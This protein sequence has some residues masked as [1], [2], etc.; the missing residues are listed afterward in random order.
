MIEDF[1]LHKIFTYIQRNKAAKIDDLINTVGP[2]ALLVTT[3]EGF[4]PLQMAALT[5]AKNE[6]NDA[7]KKVFAIIA[8]AHIRHGIINFDVTDP[9]LP[10]GVSYLSCAI[11]SENEEV[12]RIFLDIALSHGL[13]A[14]LFK[15]LFRSAL[16]RDQKIIK[17][18]FEASIFKVCAE[19]E[20][21]SFQENIAHP[22]HGLVY[23]IAYQAG[24]TDWNLAEDLLSRNRKK[25][26]AAL[27][28]ILHAFSETEW[29]KGNFFSLLC[30]NPCLMVE[31]VD[32]YGPSLV[33][34]INDGL[35]FDCH[36]NYRNFVMIAAAQRGDIAEIKELLQQG[37]LLC[38]PMDT[39]EY[40]DNS[41]N[42][43]EFTEFRGAPIVYAI[44]AGNEDAALF[45][46]DCGASH[47]YLVEFNH[48]SYYQRPI[49]QLAI[50]HGLANLVTRLIENYDYQLDDLLRVP[51]DSSEL[52]YFFNLTKVLPLI[53]GQ[54]ARARFKSLTIRLVMSLQK[55]EMFEWL[56]VT[57]DID[58][59]SFAE[60][61]TQNAWA[62]VQSLLAGQRTLSLTPLMIIS[63]LRAFLPLLAK[64]HVLRGF[65]YK[66]IEISIDPT[67]S[68]CRLITFQCAIGFDTTAFLTSC[69]AALEDDDQLLGCIEK[70]IEAALLGLEYY[71]DLIL[72]CRYPP[73]L[74]IAFKS[75]W[76]DP[77]G[78]RDVLRKIAKMTCFG[79]RLVASAQQLGN[80]IAGLIDEEIWE[81]VEHAASLQYQS[82]LVLAR[83]LDN[84]WPLS[85]DL[86]STEAER[87]LV[88]IMG[89][90]STYVLVS[91]CY[92]P[93]RDIITFLLQFY[94]RLFRDRVFR[95][96]MGVDWEEDE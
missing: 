51:R 2:D 87:E 74:E 25:I 39:T 77:K 37:Y 16:Q 14:D 33:D 85:V 4:S 64:W 78:L 19:H 81:P 6:Y 59:L 71:T 17:T 21:R 67:V 22:C 10:N 73:L 48:G 30:Y 76:G 61:M 92:V 69:L 43:R 11:L 26:R 83:E 54:Q 96:L 8:L 80:C 94:D 23:F 38:S 63:K 91:F 47:Q 32:H 20:W 65:N 9:L 84:G 86:A 36:K 24:V 58:D 62:T 57:D 1:H 41:S 82:A 66:P 88:R 18:F 40:D 79:G 29:L 93:P 7:A 46:L 45:M 27:S 90:F 28:Q 53:K 72:T 42:M 35:R 44:E 3:D 12:V 15:K 55:A 5:L 31:I 13:D 56:L 34:M 89:P 52:D 75:A 68:H 50:Q 60:G 49:T 95:D 70:Q